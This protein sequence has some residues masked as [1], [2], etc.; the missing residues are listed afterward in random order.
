MSLENACH[1]LDI[2]ISK[3]LAS[4]AEGQP[5]NNKTFQELTYNMEASLSL[6]EEAEAWKSN[7]DALQAHM[8]AMAI[9]CDEA[10]AAPVVEMLSNAIG[11]SMD[12]YNEKVSS[13]FLIWITTCLPRLFLLLSYLYFAFKLE[14]SSRYT[15]GEVFI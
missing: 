2:Q 1:A 11:E 13:F 10:A 9:Q 7:A 4:G 14:I 3:A 8:T 6:E 5:W 12:K 15:E